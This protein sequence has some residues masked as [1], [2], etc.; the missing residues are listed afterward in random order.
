MDPA[1]RS[2]LL[3]QLQRRL[4][5]ALQPPLQHL[6]DALDARLFDLAER[7]RIASQ[8]QVFFEGLR[9][10]RR[11]RNDIEHD[12]LEHVNEALRPERDPAAPRAPSGLSLVGNEELEETLTLSAMA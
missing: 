1:E 8:Q 6:F 9:E 2:R 11:K 10:C 12:F 7:S 3:A 4:Q 5:A